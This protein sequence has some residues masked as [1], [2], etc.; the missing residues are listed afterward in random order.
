MSGRSAKAL[1]KAL[2]KVPLPQSEL[3]INTK[4][5]EIR[6]GYGRRAVLQKAKGML[7]A[8]RKLFAAALNAA[9]VKAAR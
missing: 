3:M 6:R 5:G 7:P 8:A 9:A 1:R 4:S 2:S